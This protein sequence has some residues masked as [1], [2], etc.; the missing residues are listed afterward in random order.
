M[1]DKTQLVADL[2]LAGYFVRIEDGRLFIEGTSIH[3]IEWV[4][5]EDFDAWWL[6]EYTGINYYSIDAFGN[7]DEAIKTAKDLT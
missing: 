6:Y 4:I 7:M 2:E 1:T 3:G 5:E